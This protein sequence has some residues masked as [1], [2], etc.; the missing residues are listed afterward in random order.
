MLLLFGKA[1]IGGEGISYL[2]PLT[3]EKRSSLSLFFFFFLL[4]FNRGGVDRCYEILKPGRSSFRLLPILL[5]PCV[6]LLRFFPSSPLDRPL[7]SIRSSW[8]PQLFSRRRT[9]AF[10]QT[11]SMTCGSLTRSPRS[12]RSRTAK[13][14][15][16]VRLQLRFAA[17]ESA[18]MS[19]VPLAIGFVFPG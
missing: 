4:P 6:H 10:S 8:L 18:G 2:Q 16:L 17:P 14:C 15:S 5:I 7:H 1:P 12:R 3:L 11:P 13:D 9:L 19:S